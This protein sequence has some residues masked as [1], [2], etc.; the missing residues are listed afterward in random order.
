MLNADLLQRVFPDCRQPA[1]W[2]SALNPALRKYSI[3]S[4]ERVASFLA[5]T[6]YESGQYNKLDENLRYTTAARLM[7]VWPKRFPT[8]A[9]ASAYIDNP[10]KLANLV[11][12]NRMGNGEVQSGDGYRY[13]GRG[14]IQLTGRSNYS[15]AAKALGLDLLNHPDLL[16]QPQAASMSAAWFWQTRGLNELADDRTDDSDLADFTEITRRINGGTSGMGH[17]LALFKKIYLQLH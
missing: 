5:Q 7:K 9:A 2:A 8:V 16:L 11:Y 17:R 4:P 12:A 6:G 3:D 1:A 15:A 13:H 10:I 14:L